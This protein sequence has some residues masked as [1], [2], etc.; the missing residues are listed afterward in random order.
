MTSLLPFPVLQF[1][2]A[3][4]V[5]LAGGSIRTLVPNTSSPKMTWQDAGSAVANTNPI[6]LNGGGFAPQIYGDGDYTWVVRDVLGNQIYSGLT[7]ATLPEDAI[8][9]AMLPV[10]G[11]AT[12]MTAI[13]LMG[14]PA[15]IASVV[16]GLSL[17]PGPTGPTGPTGPA[18]SVGPTGPANASDT[19][20][21]NGNNPGFLQLQNVNNS[22]FNWFDQ[23]GQSATNSGGVATVNFAVQYPNACGGVLLTALTSLA[24]VNIAL[25]QFST[26]GFIVT[27]SSIAF[28]GG[29]FGGPVAFTWRA[30]GF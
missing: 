26:A 30:S 8:S 5:P 13:Q 29:G 27:T 17:L 1:L 20:I 9:Q 14:I 12:T 2:T 10:V 7:S 3:D 24:D 21:L 25:N 16:A 28:H 23:F 4:G 19:P 18:G 22:N 6:I 11:A 15:Y